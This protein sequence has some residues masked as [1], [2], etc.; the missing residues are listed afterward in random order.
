MTSSDAALPLL[1][2]CQC[3]AVRY[4]LSAPAADL[5]HCHCQMCRK[6]HGALFATF[7]GVPVEGLSI[8]RGAEELSSFES[9]PGILRQFCRHCGCPLLCRV[10]SAPGMIYFTPATIDGG[11]HPGHPAAR[12][13]HLYVGSK[14]PWYD[15]ESRLPQRD[16]V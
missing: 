6:I 3:G 12:E 8:E 5:Y 2:G 13:R 9:S 16:T 4:R 14:V 15:I 7:A 11:A 1:G 10:A